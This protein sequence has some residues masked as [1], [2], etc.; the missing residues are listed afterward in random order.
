MRHHE[1]VDSNKYIIQVVAVIYFRLH[2]Q[3]KYFYELCTF[4]LYSI[5]QF[6]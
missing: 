6:E 2:T 1:Q 4:I 5:V 3:N